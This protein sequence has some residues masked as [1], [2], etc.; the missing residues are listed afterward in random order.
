MGRLLEGIDHRRRVIYQRLPRD[1]AGEH[2]RDPDVEH[3]ANDQGSQDADG[4]IALRPVA[5]FGCR[6]DRI[7]TDV[8]KKDD[9]ATGE[10][11]GPSVRKKR[12]PMSRMDEMRS[13]DD[14]DQD[15]SDFEQ[16]HDVVGARGLADTPYQ[17]DG[18]NEND[19]KSG[20]IEA[21]MPAR[22]IDGIALKVGKAGR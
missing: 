17:H 6:R 19:E 5:L 2:N 16:N 12:M 9:A 15:G 4:D 21:E 20:K 8:G 7:E 18:Q 10:H 11:A 14:E 13:G 22:L 1:Q 3:G